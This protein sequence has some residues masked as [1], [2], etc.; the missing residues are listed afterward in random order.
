[1][2]SLTPLFLMRHGAQMCSY[3]D[4]IRIRKTMALFASENNAR[5]LRVRGL[6]KVKAEKTTV[7]KQK[8]MR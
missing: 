4:L 5:R 2:T 3:R 8:W 1:M 6:R 7:R